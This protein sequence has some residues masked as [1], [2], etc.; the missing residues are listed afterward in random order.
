ML[1]LYLFVLNYNEKNKNYMEIINTEL[2]KKIPN[3]II[4]NKTGYDYRNGGM[5]EELNITVL[6]SIKKH[7][8]LMKLQSGNVSI[9]DKL[10][11]IEE[12]NIVSNYGNNIING[13]LFD[14]WNEVF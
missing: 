11:I 2:N 10:I 6:E 5:I 7:Q 12:M 3:Y 1:N 8:I 9:F 14:D 13:G 4:K